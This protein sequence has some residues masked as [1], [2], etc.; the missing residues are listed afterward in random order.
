MKPTRLVFKW[1]RQQKLKKLPSWAKE[2]EDF[3][4]ISIDRVIMSQNGILRDRLWQSNFNNLIGRIAEREGK[5]ITQNEDWT[6]RGKL[7]EYSK[8]YQSATN[9]RKVE[10]YAKR[11]LKRLEKSPK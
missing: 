3:D 6:L 1:Y 9:S 5:W 11:L 10:A 4:K 7:E 2:F 8:C